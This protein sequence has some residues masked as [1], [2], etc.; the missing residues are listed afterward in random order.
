MEGQGPGVLGGRTSLLS[1]PRRTVTASLRAACSTRSLTNTL[2][3]NSSHKI[4]SPT[5]ILPR[6]RDSQLAE[7][8]RRTEPT[9][10][11]EVERRVRQWKRKGDKGSELPRLVSKG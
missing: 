4:A 7:R 1:L 2:A 11:G 8:H 6:E 10:E 5:P 3:I 9:F